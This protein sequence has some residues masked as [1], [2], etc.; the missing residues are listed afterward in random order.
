MKDLIERLEKA[1]GPDRELDEAIVIEVPV[2]NGFLQP[3]RHGGFEVLHYT[4]SID[5]ALTLVPTAAIWT[6]E[7][8]AA[9]VRQLSAD[10]VD[11]FQG[12]LSGRGGKCTAIALC[13]AALRARTSPPSE[14][15]G[16]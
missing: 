12:H 4:A 5:A 16:E 1:L 6:L 7:P 3:D 10:D 8:D 14:P 13:I 9:W 15:T 11:E 2:T